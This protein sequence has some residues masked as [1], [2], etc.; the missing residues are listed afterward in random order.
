MEPHDDDE[1]PWSKRLLQC[2]PSASTSHSLRGRRR[3]RRPSPPPP[4]P[5]PPPFP[6]RIMLLQFRD[7]PRC[8]CGTAGCWAAPRLRSCRAR[9]PQQQV[10]RREWEWQRVC[11]HRRRQVALSWL[12]ELELCGS[13]KQRKRATQQPAAAPYFKHAQI[14]VRMHER[15]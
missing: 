8:R 11:D 3:A 5:P 14:N 4:S 12:A 7:V 15:T 9:L 1:G 10:P 6:P 13:A 2:S